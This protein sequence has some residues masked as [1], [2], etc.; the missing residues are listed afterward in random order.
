MKTRTL[1]FGVEVD[2]NEPL[3]CSIRGTT[4]NRKA[5]LSVMPFS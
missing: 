4:K 5:S 2:G 1:M 3:K